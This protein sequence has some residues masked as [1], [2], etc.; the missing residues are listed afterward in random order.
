MTGDLSHLEDM[1]EE[2][3][4][5]LFMSVKPHDDTSWLRITADPPAQLTIEKIRAATMMLERSVIQPDAD[6]YYTSYI[7]PSL[8]DDM[9]WWKT[10]VWPRLE[11][12]EKHRRQRILKR[13]ACR[14]Q[15][16][17]HWGLHSA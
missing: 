16:C 7:P 13:L 3:A 15:S 1:T 8:V 4:L 11:W 5:R 17:S 9:E 12:K 14:P 6:G 10:H 2:M